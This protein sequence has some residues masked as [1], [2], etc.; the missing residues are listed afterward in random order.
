MEDFFP[1]FLMGVVIT[2]IVSFALHPKYEDLKACK[3]FNCVKLATVPGKDNECSTLAKS[4]TMPG[5][6][7]VCE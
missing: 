1:V 6:N 5:Y 3:D 4:I 2:I 7:L